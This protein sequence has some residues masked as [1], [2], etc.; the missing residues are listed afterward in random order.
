MQNI[1]I[2]A[3]AQGQENN[4]I[5]SEPVSQNTESAT[6]VPSDANSVGVQKRQPQ[7]F[8]PFQIILLIIMVF[9]VFM[10]FRGPRKKQQEHRKMIQSLKK[11]D[12]VRTIGGIYGT[13]V[14]VRDDE[15]VLKI[16]E[17]SNTKIKVTP[18]AIGTKL[19]EDK[20]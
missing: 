11:N 9:F 18:S 17:S 19:S 6:K 20:I 3:E 4:T 13:I 7:G 8:G 14:D 12:R 15:I 16:D 2:L 5:T 1:W 10:M